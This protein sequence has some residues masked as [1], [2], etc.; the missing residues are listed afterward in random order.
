MQ[1][2]ERS[3]RLGWPYPYGVIEARMSPDALENRLIRFD[4][5][6]AL[7]PSGVEL[8]V[9]GNAD[10]PP[11]DISRVFEASTQPFVIYLGLPV[12]YPGRANTLQSGEEAGNGVKRIFRVAEVEVRDENTGENPQPVQVRRFNA[13]LMLEDEDHTDVERL[14]LMRISSAGDQEARIPRQDSNFVPPSLV[15]SGSPVLRDLVRDL[16]NQVDAKRKELVVQIARSGFSVETLRGVQFEQMLRLRTLS[17]FAARLPHLV[18]LPTITPL[19]LYLELRELLAELTSLHPDRDQ[20]DVA[21]YDHENLF[22]AFSELSQKIRP[23]LVGT[24]SARYLQLPLK[25]DGRLMTAALLDEH[26]KGPNEYFIGIKTKQDPIEMAKLVVDADRFKLMAG[27]KARMRVFGVR[28]AEERHPPLELPSQTGLYYFRLMRSENPQMWDMIV[29]EKSM[30]VTWSEIET[31][32]F[33]ITL[34]MT[35]P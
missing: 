18:E 7:M 8:D 22:M 31:S 35:V 17:R 29:A 32:D 27:S 6:R 30:A 24:V 28:L 4:R 23:L 13:R 10:L 21:D 19:A 20:F 14:P 16:A 2:I 12:W 3:L 15:L 1:Q 33:N 25:R 9:P 11:L 26:I 34:Y 5:L